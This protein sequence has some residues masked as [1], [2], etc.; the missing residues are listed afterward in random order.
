MK[1]ELQKQFESQTP[2]IKKAGKIEYLQTFISWLHFKLEM[3]LEN[4]KETCDFCD[5]VFEENIVK[6]C[7]N[8]QSE[9]NI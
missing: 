4:K 7:S 3:S 2:T 6:I 8:C 1:T 5:G 9:N